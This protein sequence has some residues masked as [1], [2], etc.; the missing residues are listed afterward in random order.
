MQPHHWV[1]RFG[2]AGSRV[3]A[4]CASTIEQGE[5]KGNA[6]ALVSG[7]AGVRLLYRGHADSRFLERGDRGVALVTD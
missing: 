1:L 5:G 2:L 3:I 6:Y 4:W 7:R